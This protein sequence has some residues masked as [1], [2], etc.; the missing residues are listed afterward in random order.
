MATIEHSDGGGGGRLGRAAL[1]PPAGPTATRA[2]ANMPFA[3]QGIAAERSGLTA[4]P[5]ARPRTW[6]PLSR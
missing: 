2:G 3:T 5:S 6:L 1:A 4:T